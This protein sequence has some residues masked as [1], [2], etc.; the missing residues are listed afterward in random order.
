MNDTKNPPLNFL[1]NDAELTASSEYKTVCNIVTD[2]WESGTITRGAGYC[3]SMSDLIRILLAQQG[4]AAR[5]VECK[6][7]IMVKNPPS[8][9]LIGHNGGIPNYLKNKVFPDPALLDTHIVVVTDTTI[10]MIID[11]SVSHIDP[12]NS[13]PFIIERLGDSKTDILLDKEFNNSRWTYHLKESICVPSIHQ[14]NIFNRLA[15]DKK[16]KKDIFNLK[17]IL[18]LL[19]AIAAVNFVR[20]AYD[21]YQTYI[22]IDNDWGPTITAPNI[23]KNVE[24]PKE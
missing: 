13:T 12:N 3:F 22:I 21:F 9:I 18:L 7:T 8:L 17:A 16:V 5:L 24:I 11:L 23:N 6:I 14:E 1:S 10:P 19:L 2:L 20:G 4:I 15:T